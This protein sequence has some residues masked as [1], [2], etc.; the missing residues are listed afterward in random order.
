MLRDTQR[1]TVVPIDK[2]K[3]SLEAKGLVV[4]WH[5]V[6]KYS[7]LASSWRVD[8]MQIPSYVATSTAEDIVSCVESRLSSVW[9]L[10]R[11]FLRPFVPSLIEGRQIGGSQKDTE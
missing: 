1:S 4:I 11:A 8:Y 9:H 6:T 10:R 3:A 2:E 7:V 5:G